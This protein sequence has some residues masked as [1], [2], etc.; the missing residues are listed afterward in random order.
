MQTPFEISCVILCGGKSSRMGEDKALL[1]FS[2]YNSLTQYQYERLK[3]F[4]K[5][6]YISSKTNK[7]DFIDEKDL[8]LDIGEEFSPIVALQTI[9]NKL[10]NQKLFIIT[11]D[12]PLV[13]I[14]TMSKLIEN[15]YDKEICVAQTE[16]THNLCGVF[17]SSISQTIN[18][19]LEDD[20][21]KVGYLLRH[22][23]LKIIDFPNDEEFINLNNKDEYK[24]ALSII[25]KLNN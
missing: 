5:N 25:S 15:S 4:F 18:K 8:I 23:N 20:I 10:P 6:V 11:V 17:L 9:F 19:M 7:F 12:T 13:S 24:K 1:P 22:S 21:H 14:E 16:K 3:P 2:T